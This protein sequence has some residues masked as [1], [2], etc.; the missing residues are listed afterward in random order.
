MPGLPDFTQPLLDLLPRYG[1]LAIAGATFAGAVGAPVPLTPLLIAAGALSAEGTLSLPLAML[2]AQLAAVAGDCAGFGIGHH[3]GRRALRR[4]GP[5]VGLSEERME[6]AQQAVSRWGGW[7]IWLTRWLLTPV[8]STVNVLAGAN[9]YPF[10]TFLVLDA[11]G[12]AIFVG[13]YVTLGR[14]L[15]DDA[16]GPAATAG[17]VALGAIGAIFIIGGIVGARKLLQKRK[18]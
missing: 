15:G 5:K 10:R 12:T 9:G 2:I 16:S 13:G 7:V 6:G 11:I 8:A 17:K 3:L 4:F 18:T 14:F 1:Y